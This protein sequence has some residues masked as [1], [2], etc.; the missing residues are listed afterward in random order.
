[1]AGMEGAHGRY[2]ADR[3]T[4]LTALVKPGSQ[5]RYAFANEHSWFLY[6]SMRIR[7]EYR[8]KVLKFNMDRL[9]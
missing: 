1:M 8:E 4:L 9:S 2:K 5:V 7:S 3:F 6:V